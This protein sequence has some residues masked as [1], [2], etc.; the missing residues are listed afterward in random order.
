MNRQKYF[1]RAVA[2]VAAV[3]GLAVGGCGSSLDSSVT[4]TITMDG[5]PLDLGNGTCT[6]S[7]Y[8]EA[9]GPAAQARVAPDGTY[10]LKTGSTRGIRSGKYVVTVVATGPSREPP[11]GSPPMP[12]PLLTPTR[13]GTK[14]RSDLR[15][16][17]EPGTNRIDIPMKSK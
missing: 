14:Q 3:F 17:I 2:I 10:A 5:K 8:P 7:F 13:Y 16:T 6:V 11:P 1:R 9:G 12:G 4:G 15:F